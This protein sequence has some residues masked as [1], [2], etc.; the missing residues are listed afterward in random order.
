MRHAYF[1][2]L[3]IVAYASF[4]LSPSTAQTS[5]KPQNQQRA[6]PRG[7]VAPC[8]MHIAAR[9]QR[10]KPRQDA[11]SLQLRRETEQTQQLRQ[12][13]DRDITRAQE[14]QYRADALQAAAAQQ[15]TKA[16]QMQQVAR[17]ATDVAAQKEA[18]AI[19][20]M[21]Q[22]QQ[23]SAAAQ[24]AEQ[25][26]DAAKVA[27]Q[28]R[29]DQ[30]NSHLAVSQVAEQKAIV[31]SAEADAVM[32]RAQEKHN[33]AHALQLYAARQLEKAIQ[34][35]EAAT[36]A[37]AAF[38]REKELTQQEKQRAQNDQQDA[39][40]EKQAATAALD[41]TIRLR[42]QLAQ[43]I[44]N[45]EMKLAVLRRELPNVIKTREPIELLIKCLGSTQK[46]VCE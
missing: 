15:L 34:D 12:D 10:Q 41:E 23:N 1:L 26:A 16:G 40:A 39:K 35:Q 11:C 32:A 46:D 7:I 20:A 5:Q 6:A 42:T 36:A 31:R 18:Q 4:D 43:K 3:V 14:A 28:Q 44:A 13:A 17:Q 29:Q 22:A 33:A 21:Q 30:L 38:D 37:K 24:T 25:L 45:A 27:A 9:P 8:A 2:P 19:T